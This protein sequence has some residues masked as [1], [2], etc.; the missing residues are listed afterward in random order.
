MEV[1][2]N[3]TMLQASSGAQAYR[4]D[5]RVYAQIGVSERSNIGTSQIQVYTHLMVQGKLKAS[6]K[7]LQ[8][9]IAK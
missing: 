5:L 1:M 9:F 8:T 6:S 2:N 4:I 3:L 7:Y